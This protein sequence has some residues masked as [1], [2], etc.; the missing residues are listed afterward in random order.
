M[1]ESRIPAFFFLG[2]RGRTRHPHL[3]LIPLFSSVTH[4]VDP[5]T[6]VFM[7]HADGL[8]ARGPPDPSV[9]PF[10]TPA[11]LR[12]SYSTW[13]RRHNR[14]QPAVLQRHAEHD[15]DG[16]NGGQIDDEEEACHA[17]GA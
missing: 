4:H 6:V 1:E 16:Q 11:Q 10:I 9:H 8:Y 13:L 17:R 2:R 3:H 5:C 12:H 14:K 7:T 15:R